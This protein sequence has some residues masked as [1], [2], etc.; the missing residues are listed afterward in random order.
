MPLPTQMLRPYA[1]YWEWPMSSA[2][3]AAYTS[4]PPR[5]LI[6][7]SWRRSMDAGVDP[8]TSAAPLVFDDRRLGDERAAHPLAPLMPLLAETLHQVAHE[9]RSIMI[10]TDAQGRILWRYGDR[11]TMQ[12]A[13][14]VR[15]AVGYEWAERSI[16]TSGIGTTLATRRPVHVFCDEHLVRALHR[17]SGSGAPIVDPDTGQ[18]LGCV[19]LSGTK[20]RLHPST[21]A[22]VAAAA[23]LA[24]THLA[25]LMHER[26]MLLR[27][28]YDSLRNP[29][30]I[31]VTA[32]GR[33]IAGDAAGMLGTRIQAPQPGRRVC[34]PDGRAGR[35]DTFYGGF[36]LCPEVCEPAPLQL[37]LLGDGPA[38]ARLGDLR[39]TLSLR[40]AEILALLALHPRGLT[41]EQLSFLLYGDDGNPVTIRAEIHR[42]RS[43]LGTAIA[44][45]PYHL[46]VAVEADFL[47]LKP[48]LSGPDS[49]AL[50][51]AYTGPL[52][53][54][55]ES[56]EIRRERDEL[57]VQVRARILRD[58]SPDDLWIYAQTANGRTDP[59]I[60]E[61]VA[62]ALPPADHR[63]AVARIRLLSG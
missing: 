25:L 52:L 60:L 17:W 22:L 10:V 16:G 36:L 38:T 63:A 28:R 57:E 37:T 7:A 4:R 61:R 50:A 53:P 59:Q 31:L 35:L 55:S 12:I 39:L 30:A 1:D 21:V 56:P 34:L 43:Q 45:K 5:H 54:R 19:D 6:S 33:I 23:R 9:T 44:G 41:A 8:E 62:T 11:A 48:L 42:L 58:G 40:H 15:L 49:A 3:L 51:H 47:E 27:L 18:I 14:L 32:T 13:D 46:T 24:E 20:P 2:D 29:S 26:D